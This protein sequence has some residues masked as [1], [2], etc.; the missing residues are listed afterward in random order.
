VV[1]IATALLAALLLLVLKVGE[2]EETA[3][4][5]L[6]PA[7]ESRALERDASSCV[8]LPFPPLILTVRAL[9]W[10][11]APAAEPIERG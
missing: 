3:A 2:R 8:G 10:M 9:S 7:L 1:G 5:T 4:R 6:E 11:S